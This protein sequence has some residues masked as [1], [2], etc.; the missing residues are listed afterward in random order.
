MIRGTR[1]SFDI[2]DTNDCKTLGLYDTSFYSSNQTI[3]NATLQVITPF[4]DEPVEL[5]YYKNA[6]TVLNSNNL[7]ITNVNDLDLLTTLPD[8][9]Y[10]AKI[11]ICPE[12]KFWFEKSWYRTCLLECKYDKAFL[13]LNVQTCDACF[14]PEKLQKLERAR[15][16]IYG[17]K[18]NA[19]NCN[20][21]EADKLYKA[22]DKL[23][24]NL[25]LCD[26]T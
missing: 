21:K 13:K 16:Y 12:D 10:T 9:L 15:I 3:A 5:D 14:S 11:S 26:C 6:V 2:L 24:D 25:L 22:A 4:D 17:V 8:G 18:T 20:N 19:Q 7:K 1:L 23:L